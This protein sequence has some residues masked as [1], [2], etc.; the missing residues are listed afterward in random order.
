MTGMRLRPRWGF[1]PWVCAFIYHKP[2]MDAHQSPLQIFAFATIAL[3]VPLIFASITFIGTLQ[4]SMI[5][6]QVWCRGC[7]KL[8]MPC[9]LSQHTSKTQNAH[10]H[11]INNLPLA[12]FGTPSIH[13][14]A[15]R[16]SLSPNR[17]PEAI[18]NN[19]LDDCSCTSLMTYV[20]AR[21][22]NPQKTKT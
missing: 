8:F 16:S 9:G 13:C 20:T 21:D 2:L 10:C 11:C 12:H 19:G 17:I 18:S 15:S 3:L 7:D 6:V 4:L 5:P 14:A 22:G 1:I